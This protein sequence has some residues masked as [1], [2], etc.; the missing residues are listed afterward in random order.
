MLWLLLAF[1]SCASIIFL[2][3]AQEHDKNEIESIGCNKIRATPHHHNTESS[4]L[5]TLEMDQSGLEPQKREACCLAAEFV[6]CFN[7]GV[8]KTVRTG[9]RGETLPRPGASPT[10]LSPDLHWRI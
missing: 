6:W 9:V 5:R 10:G 2:G 7:L 3:D 4:V 8:N 1:V